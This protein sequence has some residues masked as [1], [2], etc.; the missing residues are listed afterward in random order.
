MYFNSFTHILM[1]FLYQLHSF[2]R[3]MYVF[4]YCTNMTENFS[5]ESATVCTCVWF[6]LSDMRHFHQ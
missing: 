5:I 1:Y 4:Y 2:I 3:F 6:T